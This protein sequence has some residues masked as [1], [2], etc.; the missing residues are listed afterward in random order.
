MVVSDQ[1]HSLRPTLISG[2]RPPRRGGPAANA[3]RWRTAPADAA[4][5]AHVRYQWT[6]RPQE[7]GSRFSRTWGG[8]DWGAVRGVVVSCCERHSKATRP[9]PQAT[10]EHTQVR[11]QTD[12]RRS[13]PC[14]AHRL[15]LSD[16]SARPASGD[17]QPAV[18]GTGLS[19]AIRRTTKPSRS[20]RQQMGSS[21]TEHPVAVAGP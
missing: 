14:V 6:F 17:S 4:E 2:P 10:R 3:G 21:P 19:W 9:P 1:L 16:R 11:R 8:S 20:I 12:C 7:V 13:W 15:V 5:A 18:R